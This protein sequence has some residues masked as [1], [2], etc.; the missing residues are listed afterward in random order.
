MPAV[1]IAIRRIESNG[2]FFKGFAGRLVEIF[3]REEILFLFGG[4]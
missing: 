2:K 3:R 1:E 4:L